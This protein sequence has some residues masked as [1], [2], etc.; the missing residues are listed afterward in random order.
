MNKDFLNCRFAPAVK[1][2]VKFD[3][4]LEGL[5]GFAALGV[6]L[7]HGLGQNW[8]DPTY[9]AAGIISYLTVGGLA[10]YIFFML[11]GFVIGLGALKETHLSVHTFYKKRLVRLYP[12]YLFAFAF[13]FILGTKNT[14]PIIV[15]NLLMLQN[16]LP[17]LNIKIPVEFNLAP[18]WSINYEMVYYLLFPLIS[19]AKPKIISI[20]IPLFLISVI[21]YYYP[22]VPTF[23]TD[24]ATG[25]I[26]WLFGLGICW[27]LPASKVV[28]VS[29]LSYMFLI[30]SYQHFAIGS[31]FL[32]GFNL[33][34]ENK[35]GLGLE[36]LWNLPLC[37]LIISDLAGRQL[38]YRRFFLI[39]S[40]LMP[41]FL[42]IYLVITKRLTEDTR[43]IAS[44]LFYLISLALF[45]EKTC[46][47]IVL[48]GL[49]FIGSI[50]Y[51]IYIF[52]WPLM[53][54][55]N[56]YY[57]YSG[58][59]SA[60]LQKFIVWTI[61]TFTLSYFAEKII[62]ARISAFF[63]KPASASPRLVNSKNG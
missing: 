29:F 4:R 39:L 47:A 12:I 35:H 5:R 43:W 23:L 50:S 46:S 58:T 63:F 57:P 52:H 33:Y 55:V 9:K 20:A 13:L 8:L 18:I 10:V 60:Y 59:M 32:K 34:S 40:Y 11:S 21:G 37:I 15:G 28:K 53:L 49:S 41:L 56:K 24:Y 62:Q 16:S 31:V 54:I 7:A 25:Y 3:H 45:A 14:F 19:L 36:I 51:A 61:L 1:V 6:F 48:K 2:K 44:T 27:L 26:F 42:V 30:M 38:P 17:Y 22:F